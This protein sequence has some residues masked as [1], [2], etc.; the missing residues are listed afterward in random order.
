MINDDIINLCIDSLAAD[1]SDMY[2]A[3]RGIA[4]TDALREFMLTKTYDLLFDRKS[5]L[6]LESEGY[7]YDMLRDE[8]AGNWKR[9]TEA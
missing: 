5:F 9:W 4:C 1:V 8:I 3:E 2:A 6:Y 7:V